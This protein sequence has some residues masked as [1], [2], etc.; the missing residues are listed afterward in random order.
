LLGFFLGF[1][2]GLQF[3]HHYQYR[4]TPAMDLLGAAPEK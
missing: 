2:S 3:R 1:F 4:K